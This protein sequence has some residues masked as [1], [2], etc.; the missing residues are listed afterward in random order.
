M[1][2][3]T[4]E[5]K[6]ERHSSGG[7]GIGGHVCSGSGTQQLYTLRKCVVGLFVPWEGLPGWL[8]QFASRLH[9][10]PPI[11]HLFGPRPTG[12]RAV[13]G[14]D[15]SIHSPWQVEEAHSDAEVWESSTPTCWL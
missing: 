14:I 6:I 10:R 7:F 15:G 2:V 1:G 4:V 8:L 11:V 12:Y 9:M 3:G 5:R 13:G